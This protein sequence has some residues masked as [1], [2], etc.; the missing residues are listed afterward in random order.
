MKIK[1]IYSKWRSLL[2][3]ITLIICWFIF[4]FGISFEVKRSGISN[5]IYLG[6]LIL[7][8]MFSSI[9]Y[10]VIKYALRNTLKRFILTESKIMF[11]K[12]HKLV[13]IHWKD[14]VRSYY[15]KRVPS[16]LTDTTNGYVFEYIENE[17][18]RKV[19]LIKNKKLDNFI[20]MLVNKEKVNLDHN[21]I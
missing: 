1:I 6:G 16:Y 10:V 11:Y 3:I 2:Y 9:S 5:N 8:V 14:M 4:F 7:F 21:D 19:Y 17:I 13:E 12:N 15:S 20:K 18:I